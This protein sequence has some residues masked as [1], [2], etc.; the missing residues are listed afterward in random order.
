MV[1]VAGDQ[2]LCSAGDGGGE[3][4]VV[5]RVWG[6]ICAG[7]WLDELGQAADLPYEPACFMRGES[8]LEVWVA[9]D[10]A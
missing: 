9:A 10:P 2:V 6:N 8:L 7:S 3:N 1:F 5:V 4:W